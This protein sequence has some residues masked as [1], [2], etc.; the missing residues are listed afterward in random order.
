MKEIHFELE[1]HSLCDS[2][3]DLEDLKIF[4]E[5]HVFAVWDFMSLLKSLQVSVTEVNLPWRPSKF[6]KKAVRFINEIVLGEESDVD[7]AGTPMDHFSMYVE[8]MDEVGANTADIKNFIDSL[9]FKYITDD[10]VK[11]F[12]AFNI[13]HALNSEPHIVAAIFLYGRENLIPELF[14]PI[15]KILESNSLHCPKLLYYLKRH[16][17]LDG[18]VHG[19]LAQNLFD[20]L[21]GDDKMKKL[22]ALEVAETALRKR[23]E[24]WNHVVGKIKCRPN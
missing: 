17:E 19:H 22:K 7:E 5:A 14:S 24:L 16:I 6:S 21:C 8:A 10:I 3:K 13:D 20:E 9:D 4:M 12:V 11:D 2:I 18:D 1:Q 23:L 15:V